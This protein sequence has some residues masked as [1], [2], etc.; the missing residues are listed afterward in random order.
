VILLL[1]ALL[2]LTPQQPDRTSALR[3]Q[4]FDAGLPRSGQW[5]NGFAVADM[6]QDGLQ[7][8]A[9]GPP[10]K[11]RGPPVI[12]LN[13]RN[14]RWRQWS[15]AQF[16]SLPFDYG[17]VAAADFDGNGTNDLAV[18]SH[19]TGVTVVLGDGRGTF[20]PS[21]EGLIYRAPN[22]PEGA[23]PFSSRAVVAV[24]W[25]KDGLMDI[26]AL[27]DG[28]RGGGVQLGVTVYEN[29]G[30]AWKPVRSAVRE[31]VFGDAIAAG[32]ID[33]DLLPDLVTASQ[34]TNYP[35]VLRL[36]STPEG[37]LLDRQLATSLPASL[38]HSTDLHDFNGDGRDEVV[39]GYTSATTPKRAVIELVSFPAAA[40]P[41]RE[42][43]SDEGNG[44]ITA[45]AAGDV[46]GDGSIDVVAAL[47]D[48]RLLT[49]RGDGRNFV[50]RDEDIAV[51]EWRRGCT[52]YAV[53]V[54][55]L[56]G[57]RRD[58]IIAAFAGESTGC[59][60]GGGVEVWRAVN[61]PA[62]RRSVRR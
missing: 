54:A 12:F 33:G 37:R 41:P 15:E 11:R 40:G 43:W 20:V 14:G 24:D 18:A 28:P 60:S 5:R 19:Y 31:Y 51:P 38:V 4:P 52:P 32:Y 49:F 13:E 23:A 7:D 55:D 50:T 8:L 2:F 21:Q 30:A 62:K 47:S 42:L 44:K 27:S 59:T 9:F 16:P 58:E 6:N 17:A 61:A 57:D 36:S 34:V 10:R 22:A 48:G 3:F 56:D 35:R 1:A 53:R 29:L 39:I 26:A 46:N 45:V 25:N